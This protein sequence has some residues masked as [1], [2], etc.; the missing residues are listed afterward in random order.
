MQDILAQTVEFPKVLVN[1]ARLLCDRGYP[2]RHE[3]VGL[4]EIAI[5]QSRRRRAAAAAVARFL[6]G[7]VFHLGSRLVSHDARVW[8]TDPWDA[9]YLGVTAEDLLK[10]ARLL[11]AAGVVR[12]QD[13]EWASAAPELIMRG[14]R[15]A[16]AVDALTGLY[17][18]GVFDKDLSSILAR[19]GA[20]YPVSLVMI[21]LDHFKNINN[22]H[23]HVVGDQ[24]LAAVGKLN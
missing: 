22:A 18:R 12:L 3:T 4:P 10:T 13:D 14:G 5:P 21:D 15:T 20:G 1:S 8:I 9:E 24:V 6:A 19:V 2:F 23:G 11:D 17:S 16:R 7:K